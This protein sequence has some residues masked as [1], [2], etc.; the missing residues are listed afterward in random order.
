MCDAMSYLLVCLFIYL[1]I[2]LLTFFLLFSFEKKT[3]NTCNF[4]VLK[5]KEIACPLTFFID[6]F[7]FLCIKLCTFLMNSSFTIYDYKK[8]FY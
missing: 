4:M 2:Y 1:F 8:C 6:L 5:N 3:V 7:H